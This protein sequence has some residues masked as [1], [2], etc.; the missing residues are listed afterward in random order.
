ML[1]DN[2][3]CKQFT[4]DFTRVANTTSSLIDLVVSNDHI[5]CICSKKLLLNRPFNCTKI[6][7]SQK[8]LEEK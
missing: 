1:V 2:F 8:T 3:G 7:L 6:K 5:K 4:T